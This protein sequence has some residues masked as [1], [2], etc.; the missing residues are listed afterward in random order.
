MIYAFKNVKVL[1]YL[2]LFLIY[3]AV[4]FSFLTSNYTFQLADEL[5][6][7]SS[8]SQVQILIQSPYTFYNLGE[9]NTISIFY[10]MEGLLAALFSP[11]L[12][13]KVFYLAPFYIASITFL[14]LEDYLFKL[15]RIKSIFILEIE[16]LV[17]S[18]IYS[19]TPFI[20]NNFLNGEPGFM[21]MESFAPYYIILFLKSIYENIN[22]KDILLGILVTSTLISVSYEFMSFVF[23]LA[24][25]FLTYMLVFMSGKKSNIL[26]LLLVYF[27]A[28]GI[29]YENLIYIIY[30]FIFSSGGIFSSHNIYGYILYLILFRESYGI[31]AY[32]VVF[33]TA[34]ISSIL[35]IL[36]GKKFSKIEKLSAFLVLEI[37][38]LGYI[39]AE[40]IRGNSVILFSI[41]HMYITLTLIHYIYYVGIVTPLSFTI[42]VMVILSNI[43]RGRVK[44]AHGL[45]IVV[46]VSE[47]FLSV[48]FTLWPAYPSM[49]FYNG[50]Y[51]HIFDKH[52]IS[53]NFL[54]ISTFLQNVGLSYGYSQYATMIPMTPYPANFLPN[55]FMPLISPGFT[56][57]LPSRAYADEAVQLLRSNTTSL[58]YLLA[59]SGIKYIVVMNYIYNTAWPNAYGAP[60]VSNWGFNYFI[61]GSPKLINETFSS[62]PAF[63]IAY[64][65]PNLTIYENKNS[66]Y[67]FTVIPFQLSNLNNISLREIISAIIYTNSLNASIHTYDD[68]IQINIS[69]LKGKIYYIVMDFKYNPNWKLICN[70]KVISGIEGPYGLQAFNVTD[71]KNSTITIVF[72]G[73]E[74]YKYLNYISIFAYVLVAVMLVITLI[75]EKGEKI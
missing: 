5:P 56:S 53:E 34:L 46:I 35:F 32:H 15:Y 73:S 49:Y 43:K 33:Y 65:A 14:Y 24:M 69:N 18:I 9:L 41:I 50:S 66:K 61:T 22:K 21:L 25:P 45:A 72:E 2:A 10:I 27:V 52:K 11:V 62:S 6:P 3:L 67:S 17:L 30:E 51:V 48:N 58:S 71:C 57:Y 19:L 29:N 23:I 38:V 1:E 8:L 64:Q 37:A 55:Y 54:E 68:Y 7:L 60:S 59:F 39:Y 20:L 63:K 26:K 12:V 28:I 70:N 42:F 47:L 4:F 74:T 40:T 36:I 31:S 16:K 75:N 13:Q 44:L